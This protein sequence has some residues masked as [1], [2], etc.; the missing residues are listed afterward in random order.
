MKQFTGSVDD[1]H[2]KI[3]IYLPTAPPKGELLYH[4]SSKTLH[5]QLLR[6][7][8]TAVFSCLWALSSRCCSITHIW[9]V[10]KDVS[11]F[12]LE[13]SGILRHLLSV[14]EYR[15]Q[16]RSR[17]YCTV[18]KKGPVLSSSKEESF[19]CALTLHVLL[20]NPPGDFPDNI[21]DSLVAGFIE[22]FSYIRCA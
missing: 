9:D 3:R 22:M 11:A 14:N 8:L 16:M 15:H 19:R 6:P 18:S 1:F 17:M 7:L 21:R 20:E 12:H 5:T 10:A 2:S 4:H 13:Y